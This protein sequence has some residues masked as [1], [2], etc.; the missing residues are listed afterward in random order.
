MLE[1]EVKHL[2]LRGHAISLD[3]SFSALLAPRLCYLNDLF[4]TQSLGLEPR[5]G[6]S[7]DNL[8]SKSRS[9]EQRYPLNYRNA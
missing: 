7:I 5:L 4:L 9:D 1:L 3:M 8:A 2:L 6:L